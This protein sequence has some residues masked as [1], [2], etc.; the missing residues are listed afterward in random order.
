MKHDQRPP[1]QLA[2]FHSSRRGERSARA[3]LTVMPPSPL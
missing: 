2:A 1:H 3:K